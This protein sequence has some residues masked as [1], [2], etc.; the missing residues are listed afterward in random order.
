MLSLSIHK[1]NHNLILGPEYTIHLRNIYG[2]PI[3]RV[4]KYYRGINIG[5]RYIFNSSWK[6]AN[7]FFQTNFSFYQLKFKAY[8]L[9]YPYVTDHKELIIEN[10]AGIGFNYKLAPQFELSGGIGI[11][12]TNGFFLM[13]GQ[14]IP[15]SFLGIEYKFN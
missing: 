10:T 13:I 11:G 15:H 9:G 8:Q 1:G 5:Y 2:D 4:E 12:S 3:D 14:F 7:L 6:K